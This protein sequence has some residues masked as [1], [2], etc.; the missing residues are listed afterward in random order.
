[1]KLFTLFCLFFVMYITTL[2]AQCPRDLSNS[3]TTVYFIRN[4]YVNI[5][6]SFELYNNDSFI[7]RL[8][9]RK[10]LKYEC[11]SGKQLFWTA[12]DNRDFLELD[13]EPGQT[14]I[15]WVEYKI[16]FVKGFIKLRLIPQNSENYNFLKQKFQN[17]K[18]VQLTGEEI[19]EK[20][21]VRKNYISRNLKRYENK[22]QKE[23][24]L[25]YDTKVVSQDDK[26]QTKPTP[27]ILDYDFVDFPFSK[28]SIELL[29]V[30][31]LFVNPSMSQSLN[32]AA[33]FNNL[34]REGIYRLM[35]KNPSTKPYYKFSIMMADILTY[36]PIPLSIGWEHEEFHRA[37]FLKHG[38]SSYNEMNNFPI[39]KSLIS[40]LKVKDAD[41]IRLKLESPQ[42]QVRMSEAGLEGGYLL[43]NTINKQAFYYNTKSVSYTPLIS[44]LNSAFYV[45]MC[46]RIKSDR[47]TDEANTEEGSNI[48]KRD[49]LGFD[50]TSWVYDLFRPN[51]PYESRGIHPSGVG[52]NRY[53]KR[54]QLNHDEL[55]Y[56]K[57]HGYLQF[58]NFINPMTLFHTSYTLQEKEN[59]DD[60]RAN[61]YFNHW[62]SP[63][64]FDISTTGLL[65]YDQH[66]YA[67]SIHNY[68]NYYKWFPGIEIE[69]YN[70]LLG[71]GKLKRPI[72][73]S[74]RAMLWLQPEDQLFFAKHGAFGGFIE[75]KIHYP[76]NKHF[77][78]YI[79]VSAK[80]NGWVQGN[81]YLEKNI[82][83]EFGLRAYF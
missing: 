34:K 71:E 30:G 12:A 47:M 16:G 69:T 20:T 29:G 42:D 53:I 8:K 19:Q 9:A 24:Q 56:L 72:P 76:F 39:I 61:L 17:Q 48:A 51:E 64:G 32:I 35:A 31:G 68:A 43:G 83:G 57:L 10:C 33:S 18:N 3:K 73:V 75:T 22:K 15:L 5:F 41:L 26:T 11:N 67:L 59:G 37:V 66:N 44:T 38:G 45:F 54:S 14:Y 63:F 49:L 79:S 23:V 6:R 28:Q 77:Q 74:A 50:F 82:S 81:V 2:P 27:I 36:L 4:E 40:V 52:I 58:I 70:Y 13:L 46:S 7:G 1:M 60:T 65:H 62:L 25:S 21:L 78:P 80:S 55:S